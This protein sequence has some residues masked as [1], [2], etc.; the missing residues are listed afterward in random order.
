MK[1]VR[2]DGVPRGRHPVRDQLVPVEEG[3]APSPL[4]VAA[5]VAG[6]DLHGGAVS[7]AGASHVEAETGPATN[8]GAVS[9]EIPLLV[10]AAVAVV[11]LHPGARRRGEV[12]HV[13]ALV[14]VHLQLAVGQGGPLL[15]HPAVA[16]PDLQQRA[17]GRGKPWHIQAAV[18][19]HAPQDPVVPPPPLL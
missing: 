10:A 17:I 3:L 14:A 19:A 1:A 13:E 15:V 4:L 18:G 11:D 16:I 7:S 5:T 8:D 12:R 2:R 6:P 9:V